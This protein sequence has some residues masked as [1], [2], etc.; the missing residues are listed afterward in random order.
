[1]QDE[2]GNF[3]WCKQHSPEKKAAVRKRQ[4][5]R[6][7][8]Q[9]LPSRERAEAIALLKRCVD[10]NRGLVIIDDVAMELQND[11]QTFLERVK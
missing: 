9:M 4:K 7:E 6:F 10:E 2:S 8:S 1:V 3:R 5:E 11:I